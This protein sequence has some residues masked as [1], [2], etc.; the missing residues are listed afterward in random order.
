MKWS[1]NTYI[2]RQM[3]RQIDDR[4]TDIYICN[5]IL[6]GHKKHEI[7]PFAGMYLSREYYAQLNKSEK[8]KYCTI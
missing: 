7:R 6:L 8:G 5:G 1:I 4:Y 3:D 2:Y